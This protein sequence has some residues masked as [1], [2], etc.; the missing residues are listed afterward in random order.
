MN[1]DVASALRGLYTKFGDQIL[2]QPPRL[3]S[4]LRDE[5]PERRPEISALVKALEE[6]VPQDLLSSN[7]G[8]PPRSLAARL[9]KRL[10]EEHLLA[11]DASSW[12]VWAWAQGL[13]LGDD[14]RNDPDG[15]PTIPR[16]ALMNAVHAQH[17]VTEP[18]VMS[19]PAPAPRRVQWPM[20]IAVVAA[21]LVGGYFLQRVALKP[22]PPHIASIDVP[23][24]IRVGKPYS[25]EVHFDNAKGGIV[26][27]ERRVIKSDV[28]WAEET[29]NLTVTG[30][31]QQN[32]GA[33]QYAFEAE[34][35]PSKS[36]LQFVLI[37][38]HGQ[39]SEPQTV[40]Y[41]VLP[42]PV[43]CN[44]CGT[45]LDI[46]MV[47][48]RRKPRGVGAVTGAVVGGLLGS[49]IGKGKG[50]TAAT[51]A[52]AVGGG[53]AGHAIEGHMNTTHWEITVRLNGGRRQIIEA[54]TE[55]AWRVG[56]SV[57]LVDGEIVA[58]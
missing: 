54:A 58:L 52:G 39:R 10:S 9:S 56:Q 57:K 13:G 38:R 35:K 12:A 53:I 31:D 42:A 15:P 25:F 45:I 47:N 30:M 14:Y 40:S 22:P 8:E 41:E 34:A 33:I 20:W 7:S 16:S 6:R 27:V 1:D 24:R 43:V 50:K 23:Q 48:E 19:V 44:S 51:A 46:Q 17:P 37:D 49:L 36:T 2:N 28:K 5:C 26:A 55:P 18:M 21:L 11:H 3:A 29:S 4:L 32:Q